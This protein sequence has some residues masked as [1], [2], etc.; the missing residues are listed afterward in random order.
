[1]TPAPL[2]PDLLADFLATR[3]SIRDFS[4]VEVPKQVCERLVAAAVTAPSSSNRQPWRFA[5][6]RRPALRAELAAAVAARADAMRRIIE[7]G[8]H[9]EDF[10]RYSDFFH[11]PLERAALI[12]IPQFR[13][14]PD[15]L[16][17]LVRS[18]GGNPDD[19][20]TA[21]HMRAELCSTSAAVMLLLLAAH[22]EGLGA[23]W[24]AGPM[25]AR[26]E[27]SRLL[28][29]QSPWQMVGAIALG[30]PA[31]SPAAPGRKPPER[32]VD[33]FE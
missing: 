13:E 23:C 8:H 9:A 18:G 27:I 10:N 14:T 31:A 22:A 33:W 17:N 12:I 11:E 20:P 4:P 26:D 29:I 5:V 2:S 24:M 6:V 28:H 15:L 1:M 19:F 30:Y 21:S 32:V 7:R 3:R 25:V 16:A